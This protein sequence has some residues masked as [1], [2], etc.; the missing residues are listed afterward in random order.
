[1]VATLAVTLY[2]VEA[3]DPVALKQ[4]VQRMLKQLLKCDVEVYVDRAE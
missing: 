1:M 3:E 2:G 4:A